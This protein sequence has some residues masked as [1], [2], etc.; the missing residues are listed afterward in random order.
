M[1]DNPI[2]LLA[3]EMDLLSDDDT[4][5]L[6]QQLIDSGAAWRLPGRYGRFAMHLIE[7]GHCMFGPEPTRSY[8][9]HTIPSR[10][11]LPP[12][13]PGSVEYCQ[14]VREQHTHK[15]D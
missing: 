13:E 8:W 5:L 14:R 6:F 2:D 12:E 3:W 4:I 15:S 1:P 7:E 11:D 9:G 10:H